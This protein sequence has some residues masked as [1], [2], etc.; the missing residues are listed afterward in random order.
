M[1]YASISGSQTEQRK[2]KERREERRVIA[3]IRE[4]ENEAAAR[5]EGRGGRPFAPRAGGA[6]GPGS[7]APA[8]LTAASCRPRGPC[9]LPFLP[10][11][12]SGFRRTAFI[13]NRAP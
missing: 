6:A 5:G 8:R 10:F 7:W 3:G 9:F 11:L 2:P 13:P 12:C 4:R 1:S